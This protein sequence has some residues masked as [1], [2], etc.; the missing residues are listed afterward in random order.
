V[1]TAY[2][3]GY[4]A[5]S[6]GREAVELGRMLAAGTDAVLHLCTVVADR[7]LFETMP[8]V[9][10]EYVSFLSRQARAA[11]DET[12][13]AVGGTVP[14]EPHVQ[15]A[16]SPAAGLVELAETLGAEMIVLGSARGGLAR[17]V[18]GSTTD[19]LLHSAPL[20]LAL[21]TREFRAPAGPLARVTCGV[22]GGPGR[23]AAVEVA[24][25]LATSHGVPLRL[26]TLLVANQQ[27]GQA[28]AGFDAE[29]PVLAEWRAKVGALH[30]QVRVGLGT[31]LQAE[32]GIA[33]GDSWEEA[34]DTLG[35]ADAE[36][37]VVGSG[38]HG[39]AH[40]LFLG[41]HANKI[42]RSSPVPVVAAPGG[43]G[44]ES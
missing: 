31:D 40:R 8:A 26:A 37:L 28:G 32:S 34:L 30:D 24:V 2:V 21:A 17:L 29:R 9:D 10:L 22:A 33:E 6:G 43:A 20:P 11:L 44:L 15:P 5:D 14:V 27:M 19:D 38:Q 18:V 16:G 39:R 36:V 3:V 35:W 1:T 12:A 13:S 25:R 23:E 41:S 42:V 4:S 7:H